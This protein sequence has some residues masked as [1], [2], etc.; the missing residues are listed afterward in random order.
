M[1]IRNFVLPVLLMAFFMYGCGNNLFSSIADDNSTEACVYE[2]SKNM[3]SGNYDD[4]LSSAC[5]DSFQKGAAYLGKSGFDVKD[6]INSLSEA[7]DSTADLNI[8]LKS[9]V[10][11]VS[12][13][14]LNNLEA[15]AAAY[16]EVAPTSDSYKDAQFYKA[17]VKTLRSLSLLKLVTDIDGDG[18]LSECDIN[19]NGTPDDVDAAACALVDVV[20]PG[21]CVGATA[22]RTATDISIQ[23]KSET[24]RGLTVTINGTPTA[25]CP[26]DYKQLLYKINST[27]GVATVTSETCQEESPNSSRTWPCPVESGGNALDLVEQFDQAIT[28]SIDALGNSFT[29]NN[30]IL[31]SIQDIKADACGADAV[32]SSTEIADYINSITVNGG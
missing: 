32:C 18:S 30:D 3:D 29:T 23:N 10:T 22:T 5:L 7:Q 19:G 1:K 17:I 28:D 21:S 8:Y 31:D 26:A 13:T 15:S 20:S 27:Y 12:E 2:T 25:S 24:Y 6:V 14:S 11:T 4:V 16:D 9:L